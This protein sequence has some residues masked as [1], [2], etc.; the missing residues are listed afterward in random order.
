MHQMDR[1]QLHSA[2]TLYLVKGVGPATLNKLIAK[3][4]LSLVELCHLSGSVLQ[5]MGF[6]PEQVK[7]IQQPDKAM[8]ERVNLWLCSHAENFVLTRDSSNYPALLKEISDPPILL[9]GRGNSALLTQPQLAMVGSRKPS[10][11]G[12]Q[13][14]KAFAHRLEQTG[15]V[16]TSGLALGIDTCA[17]QGALHANGKTIAVLGTGA[18]VVYPKRNQ[19]LAKDILD[20]NGC[21]VSEFLPG[22]PA[23]AEH[24]PRRNRIISGLSH[25]TLVVEAAIKSGS[26]ITA[27]YA[28]EQNREVFA[29]PGNIHNPSAEGCH[30]LIKQGAKLVESI[31]D[32]NEEF[33]TLSFV[34]PESLEKNNKKSDLENLASDKLLVSVDYEAT[35]I[36][37]VAERSGIPAVEVMAQLLEYEL[38]GLVAS[39]PGGYIKLGGK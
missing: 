35:S 27:R 11:S 18:D 8:L 17:H 10:A 13:N 7:Q 6:N 33:Q 22:T 3:S 12:M 15:W 34:S 38:R 36:D 32:I 21:I 9:F 30:Y 14:A 31:A 23:K 19:T 16:I 2:L 24:F 28:L 39:V 29:V 5:H 25:G 20:N 1:E 37:L 26:L 4:H